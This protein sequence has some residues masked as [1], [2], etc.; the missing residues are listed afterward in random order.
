MADERNTWRRQPQLGLSLLGLIVGVALFA[1]IAASSIAVVR[2]SRYANPG[3]PASLAT[4]VIAQANSLILAYEVAVNK[5]G[6]TASS[7]RF[8][9][10]SLYSASLTG[11][12]PLRLLP[13]AMEPSRRG[14]RW[15]LA[16]KF[17]LPGFGPRF[18]A[19]T[20]EGAEVAFCLAGVTENVC[21][22]VN[23]AMAGGSLNEHQADGQSRGATV[24]ID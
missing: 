5:G 7:L 21:R 14:W 23:R 4:A 1:V 15:Q 19:R 11:L 6:F 24:Y 18:N 2:N 16:R 12:A 20:T 3:Q 17:R 22:E 8:S 9:T 13:D 10:D